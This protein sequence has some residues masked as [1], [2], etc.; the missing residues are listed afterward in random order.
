MPNVRTLLGL[1]VAAVMCVAL[2]SHNAVAE[3]PCAAAMVQAERNIAT[4][5]SLPVKDKVKE[6]TN[7]HRYGLK[8]AAPIF[9][10]LTS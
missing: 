1:A 4:N 8:G 2:C 10:D 3:T 6:Y 5:T 7:I 9:D